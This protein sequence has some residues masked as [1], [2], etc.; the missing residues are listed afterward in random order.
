MLSSIGCP[1][2]G[3]LKYGDRRSNP[4]GSIS[5][6][7]RRV[8]LTHPVSRQP[9]VIEAPTPDE[10]VWRELEGMAAGS[11]PSPAGSHDAADPVGE[12]KA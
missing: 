5:L 7:A 9:L 4:D 10:R 12:Q 11:A 8:E 2:R 6:L 1:V 3:D